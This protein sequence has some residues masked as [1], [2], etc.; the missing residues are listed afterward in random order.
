MESTGLLFYLVTWLASHTKKCPEP[1]P[2][3]VS[4]K[5]DDMFGQQVLA[6]AQ[7]GGTVT[8]EPGRSA[9]NCRP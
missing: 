5:L 7:T 4:K 9:N 1:L 3:F 6:T 2:L 8:R